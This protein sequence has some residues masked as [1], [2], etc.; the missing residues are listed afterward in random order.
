MFKGYILTTHEMRD[1][2]TL[3]SF[4]TKGLQYNVDILISRDTDKIYNQLVERAGLF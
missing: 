2:L 4:I 1:K 3:K